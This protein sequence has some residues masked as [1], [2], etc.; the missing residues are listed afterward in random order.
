M[1]APP[2]RGADRLY[3]GYFKSAPSSNLKEWTRLRG[4]RHKLCAENRTPTL[5][6]SFAKQHVFGRMKGRTALYL[7][8]QPPPEGAHAPPPALTDAPEVAKVENCCSVFFEPHLGHTGAGRFLP[9]TSFSKVFLHFWQVYSK[10][11]ITVVHP[12]FLLS[13]VSSRPD[14]TGGRGD[15]VKRDTPGILGRIR[16][17]TAMKRIKTTMPSTS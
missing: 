8:R 11:G 6:T 4:E 14:R 5:P 17:H 16:N 3:A 12:Q 13:G 7:R 2:G 10:I 9:S 15:Q 1:A